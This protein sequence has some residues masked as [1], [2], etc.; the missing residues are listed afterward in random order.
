M[1][2]NVIQ[3]VQLTQQIVKFVTRMVKVA[4][5]FISL[6]GEKFFDKLYSTF[7]KVVTHTEVGDYLILL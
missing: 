4:K 2:K 7:S 6:H 5:T 1:I 3:I